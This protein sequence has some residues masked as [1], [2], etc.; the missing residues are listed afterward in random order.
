ML[1]FQMLVRYFTLIMLAV[2]QLNFLSKLLMEEQRSENTAVGRLAHRHDY[3]GT[4]AG[5]QE[6]LRAAQQEVSEDQQE[7]HGADQQEVSE[8]QQ[9]GL[10]AVQ[11]TVSDEGQQEGLVALQQGVSDE[12]QQEGNFRRHPRNISILRPPPHNPQNH[13]AQRLEEL[14]A[15]YDEVSESLMPAVTRARQIIEENIS[16]LNFRDATIRTFFFA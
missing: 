3:P 1:L 6:G 2:G 11:Q 12:G 9:E 15:R 16:D 4:D 14:V 13:L 7:G 5:Q 8:G 10:G